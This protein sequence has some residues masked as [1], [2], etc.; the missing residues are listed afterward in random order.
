LNDWHLIS[1]IVIQ[2]VGGLFLF[3]RLY[4][5]VDNLK[6][7]VAELKSQIKLVIDKLVRGDKWE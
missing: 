1:A 6:E 5:R 4:E 2:T 7:E 3:G